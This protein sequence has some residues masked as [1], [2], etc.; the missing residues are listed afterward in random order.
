MTKY[1][2]IKSFTTKVHYPDEG[3]EITVPEGYILTSSDI[4]CEI[5]GDKVHLK[6]GKNFIII[7]KKD[8]AR[9]FDII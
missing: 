3:T 6:I 2:C 9:L 1:K 7:L 8:F 5:L 4:N